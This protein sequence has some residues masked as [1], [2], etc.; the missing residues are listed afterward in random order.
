MPDNKCNGIV[1]NR[2]P[3]I[4]MIEYAHEDRICVRLGP[5]DLPLL[6]FIES[7]FEVQFG[8]CEHVIE[9]IH[10]PECE[11]EPKP[12]PQ[13]RV[14]DILQ[15]IERKSQPTP[16]VQTKDDLEETIRLAA[17]PPKVRID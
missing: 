8:L 16:K 14:Q 12:Q 2:L 6:T 15:S 9:A 4:S 10:T 7:T 1:T 11:P 5:R 13:I 17:I 3:G